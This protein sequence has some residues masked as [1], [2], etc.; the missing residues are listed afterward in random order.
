MILYTL[1]GLETFFDFLPRMRPSW[2][3]FIL[4][5]IIIF[6]FDIFS[7][8]LFNIYKWISKN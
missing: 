1:K 7:L 8:I 2:N 5:F 4:Y 6:F 3:D